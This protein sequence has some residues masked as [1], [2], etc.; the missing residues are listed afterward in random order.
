MQICSKKSVPLIIAIILSIM[1]HAVIIA[2]IS[3]VKGFKFTG[4]LSK[5]IQI[6]SIIK[7][8][9]HKHSIQIKPTDSYLQENPSRKYQKIHPIIF[10]QERGWS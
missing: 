2:G 1:L 9:P 6:T 8:T 7:E 4:S 5:S 3:G 10:H